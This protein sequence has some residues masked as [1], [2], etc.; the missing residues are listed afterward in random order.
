[1]RAKILKEAYFVG[2]LLRADKKQRRALLQTISTRQLDALV[3]I[4][5][6]ILHGYGTLTEKDKKHLRRY[7]SVIR[8]FVNRRMSHSRRKQLLQ[9]YYNI[10]FRLIKVIQKYLVAEWLEK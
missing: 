8:N 5:Y 4:V 7:Q 10:F 3:E 6:N 2:L 1:M 9:K